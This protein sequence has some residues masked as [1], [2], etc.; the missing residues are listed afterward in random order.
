MTG[1]VVSFRD[2]EREWL[3]SHDDKGDVR[4]TEC[5]GPFLLPARE[6]KI[7]RSMA[8]AVSKAIVDFSR[9]AV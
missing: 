3:V 1:D 5:A 4:V 9:S 6:I 7:S 8:K 2:G